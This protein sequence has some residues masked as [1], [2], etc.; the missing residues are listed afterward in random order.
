MLLP[1]RGKPP[2]LYPSHVGLCSNPARHT[3][4]VHPAH[5]RKA[6]RAL[7]TSVILAHGLLRRQRVMKCHVCRTRDH[8]STR[9]RCLMLHVASGHPASQR[10]P[11]RS[12]DSPRQ[13]A[14]FCQIPKQ[15]YN[16]PFDAR[17]PP[18]ELSGHPRHPLRSAGRQQ[19]WQLATLCPSDTTGPSD[20]RRPPF[21][22]WPRH[23]PLNFPSARVCPSRHPRRAWTY[24]AVGPRVPS[25]VPASPPYPTNPTSRTAQCRTSIPVSWPPWLTS[26][27]YHCATHPTLRRP[28][29]HYHQ[30]NHSRFVGSLKE[31]AKAC[32]ACDPGAYQP[33]P[34]HPTP[35]P[36]PPTTVCRTTTRASWVR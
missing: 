23:A 22:L 15:P 13:S 35:S 18:F 1:T 11:L 8:N 28:P 5:P 17:R 12:A 14:T 36:P 3:G 6:A 2:T 26:Y 31:M 16:R 10:R 9:A 30:D 19:P 21:E 4:A 32:T 7:A 24:R 25:R 27:H 29:Y 34:P 20:A 33:N